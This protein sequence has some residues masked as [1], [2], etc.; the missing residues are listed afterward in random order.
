VCSDCKEKAASA[1]ARDPE[2]ALRLWEVSAKMVGL[3]NFDPFTADSKK[4][5]TA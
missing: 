3:T 5:R 2:T 1:K 4:P